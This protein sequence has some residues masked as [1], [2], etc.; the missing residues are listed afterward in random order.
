M[1]SDYRTIL[2]PCYVVM[3]TLFFIYY[4]CFLWVLWIW[5]LILKLMF[6]YFWLLGSQEPSLRPQ[7]ISYDLFIFSNLIFH[8]PQFPHTIMLL[9]WLF[10]KIRNLITNW[11]IGMSD[12]WLSL[13]Q[14]PGVISQFVY[15]MHKVKTLFEIVSGKS[16]D[17]CLNSQDHFIR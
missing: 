17:I 16:E 11:F 9:C 4:S 7:T 15:I 1:A 8:L 6:S 3:L 2:L 14:F 10:W 12:K 13:I 5:G